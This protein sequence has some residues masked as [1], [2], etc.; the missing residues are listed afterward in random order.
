M[1]EKYQTRRTVAFGRDLS[2]RSV[3][4]LV[5]LGAVV[6]VLQLGCHEET[7]A[8][9]ATSVQTEPSDRVVVPESDKPG[10]VVSADAPE[11]VEVTRLARPQVVD[12]P[13]ITLSKTV[14]DFGEIGP[15]T[16]HSTRFE[17]KNEGTFPL[18]ITQVQ[19]CCGVVTRGVKA[20]QEYAPGQSGILEV[21]YRAGEMPTPIRKDLHI[22]SNDPLHGV[23]TLTI[24]AEV[25]RRIDHTPSRLKL[26]LR[27][28]NAGARDIT[29]T[30]LDGRAFSIKGF[31]ATAKAISAD[32]DPAAKDTKFVL[33]PKTDMEKL[34]RHLRGWIHI[35]LTHP[36]CKSV[37]L[38]FDVLPEFSFDIEQILMFNLKA[39]QPVK[40]EIWMLSN[41]QDD[42]ELESVTSQKGT[43]KLLEKEKVENRYRLKFEITPPEL[44]SE[45]AV[46]SDVIEIKVKDGKT[47][48]IPCRGFY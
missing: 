29:L 8:P 46:M 44:A 25:A 12:A 20:G 37:R 10:E 27:R 23:V 2:R 34:K 17:F 31:R 19:S 7:A 15:G 1:N 28:E 30:S 18:R 14:H 45:R 11:A 3:W 43:V 48:S 6:L 24:K 26:F 35:D 36:E 42:F 41:Y 33:K 32:F 38:P 16:A 13:K 22:V 40:R 39:G 9:G 21:D 4:G 47:L 5:L